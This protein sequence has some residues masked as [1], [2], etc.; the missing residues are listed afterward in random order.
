M[1]YQKEL[2]DFLDKCNLSEEERIA[3]EKYA[4][5]LHYKDSNLYPECGKTLNEQRRNSA[6]LEGAVYK[7]HNSNKWNSFKAII[8][9]TGD[10]NKRDI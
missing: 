7:L 9:K 1:N 4:D 5:G 3:F 8:I 10:A 6:A 2:T